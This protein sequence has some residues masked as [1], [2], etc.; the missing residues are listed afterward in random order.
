MFA[1][2]VMAAG[3]GGPRETATHK[4]RCGQLSDDLNRTERD[5]TYPESTPI[6]L[7][8]DHLPYAVDEV[9]HTQT[10][11]EGLDGRVEVLG[12]LAML[13]QRLFLGGRRTTVTIRSMRQQLLC[14][15][16]KLALSRHG[17]GGERRLTLSMSALPT[18]PICESSSPIRCFRWTVPCRTVNSVDTDDTKSWGAMQTADAGGTGQRVLLSSRRRSRAHAR[19]RA[20][21][22]DN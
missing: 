15:R 12:D 10:R 18:S 22:A 6:L 13:Q 9:E 3:G 11:L 2:G 20:P 8:P 19:R 21:A 5:E 14:T 17:L 16:E 7:L 1:T 4:Q